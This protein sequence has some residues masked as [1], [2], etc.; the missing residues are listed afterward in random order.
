MAKKEY[1]PED[2]IDFIELE[3]SIECSKCKKGDMVMYSDTGEDYFFEAGWRATKDNVYCP[4]CAKK[5]LK[6]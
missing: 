2:L 5:K 6:Q 4:E 1:E 3:A